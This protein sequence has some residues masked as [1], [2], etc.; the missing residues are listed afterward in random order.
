MLVELVTHHGHCTRL[1]G[2]S[3][4]LL[5]MI[6]HALTGV[7]LYSCVRVYYALLLIRG[8]LPIQFDVLLNHCYTPAD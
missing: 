4:R 6:A 5:S 3:I 7:R 1:Y 2:Q 8:R